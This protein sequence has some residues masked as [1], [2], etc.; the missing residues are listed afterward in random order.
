[1]TKQNQYISQ[2]RNFNKNAA[3]PEIKEQAYSISDS[4]PELL[5]SQRELV[6][7]NIFDN[8]KDGELDRWRMSES[9]KAQIHLLKVARIV[10]EKQEKATI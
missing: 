8:E 3:A 7:N 6:S 2:I 1:M 9:V 4:I 5:D 10:T